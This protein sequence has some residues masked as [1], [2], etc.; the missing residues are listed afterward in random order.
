MSRDVVQQF[1]DSEMM[2]NTIERDHK[3][4]QLMQQIDTLNDNVERSI[5]QYEMTVSR[6]VGET[7]SR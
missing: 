3:W 4:T 2:T 5:Q 6:D 1:I 7:V